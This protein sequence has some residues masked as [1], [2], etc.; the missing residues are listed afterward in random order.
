MSLYVLRA[1]QRLC[2]GIGWVVGLVVVP[3][4]VFTLR[5]SYGKR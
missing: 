5:G 1:V 3:Q 4:I 2:F